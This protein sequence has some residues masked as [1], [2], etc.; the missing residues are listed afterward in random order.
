MQTIF[1]K[2]YLMRRMQTQF[3][4]RTIKNA[5]SVLHENNSKLP[6]SVLHENTKSVIVKNTKSVLAKNTNIKIAKF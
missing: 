5:K 2:M 6:K 3:L 4:Q 1:L